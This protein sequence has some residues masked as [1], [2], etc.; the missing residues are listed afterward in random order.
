MTDLHPTVLIIGGG[1]SGLR[2]AAELAP[3]VDGQV[4]VLERE[5]SAGGIPRHSDHPGYGIRDLHRFISGPKYATMLRDRALRAGASVMENATVTGWSGDLSLQV[6][7]PGGRITVT[8]EAVV[9]ATGARERPRAARLIPGD[10]SRGVYTTG[11][12]QNLVHRGQEK[13]GRR[14]VIVGSELVSFSA[15]MTLRHVGCRTVLMTSEHH[16]PEA[17]WLFARVGL[18]WFRTEVATRTRVRNIIGRPEVSGVEIEDIDTGERRIIDCDTVILTGDWI[19][20]NELARAAGL[21]MDRSSRSP[22]IDAALRTSRPGVFAI[23]NLVHPVDTADVAAL[24]GAAVAEHVLAHLRGFRAASEQVRLRADAP[25]RWVSPGV[26]RGSDPE[27]PRG[28]LL[29]WSDRYVP[30]PRVVVRQNGR[31]VAGKRLWWPAA[32]GRVFRVP[33][34][35]LAGIDLAAGD[36]TIGVVE[37]R[38]LGA[39][40][41][42][43]NGAGVRT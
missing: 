31:V 33:S 26:L 4:L 1:P 17:Y 37:K 34:R 25:L 18:P 38:P 23:G 13:V 6:T 30:F 9:L 21:E 40:P 24:D 5:S 29:L 22:L 39:E 19:G 14:A 28:R 41:E 2:A 10:R 32:P 8:A 3:Q 20:D 15:A 35:I 12:L 7:T 16:K 43:P 36:L 11:H 42:R 27:P